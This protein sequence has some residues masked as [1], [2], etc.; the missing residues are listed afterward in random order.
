[1]VRAL[2][3]EQFDPPIGERAELDHRDRLAVAGA[4][5]RVLRRARGDDRRRAAEA[6]PRLV[7]D[8]DRLE[9]AVDDDVGRLLGLEVDPHQLAP[10]RGDRGARH[11]R[12]ALGEPR[13]HLRLA[14]RAEAE[15]VR[16]LAGLER[17]DGAGAHQPFFHQFEQARVDPVDLAAQDL[18]VEPGAGSL[19]AVA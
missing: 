19:V 8:Q 13:D 17:G 7:G 6:Q 14:G 2:V 3:V 5:E 9:R 16:I 10:D 4:V 18:Q 11:L 12:R 15:L 1:M